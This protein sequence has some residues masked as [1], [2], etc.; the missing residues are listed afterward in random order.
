MTED[1]NI[2]NVITKKQPHP[3]FELRKSSNNPAKIEQ[4]THA[5]SDYLLSNKSQLLIRCL[6]FQVQ[7]FRLFHNPTV[8]Q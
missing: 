8:C 1:K 5:Q 6:L 7:Y 4:T 2:Q 3:A